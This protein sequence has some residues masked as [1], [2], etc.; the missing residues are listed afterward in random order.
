[1]I[2]GYRQPE[3]MVL[4]HA[5]DTAT[6][7]WE[8]LPPLPSPMPMANAV[9]VGDR[10]FVLGGME[11]PRS[12]EYDFDAKAWIP[13]APMPVER[14]RG[15]ASIGVHGTTVL[16]AGGVL[17][18][19]SINN[20]ATGERMRDLLPTTRLATC[21]RPGRSCRSPSATPHGRGGRRPVLRA[22][23]AATPPERTRSLVFDV[24]ARAWT[25]ST[26]LPLTLSSAAAGVIGGK[27]VVAGGIAST[28]GM[29]NPETFLFD[30][31]KPA[32]G[33]TTL[34]PIT[35][36]RFAMGGA[37]VDNRLYV[38]TGMTYRPGTNNIQVQAVTTFEAFVPGP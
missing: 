18:G 20:L 22:W 12:I 32:A 24:K 28:T 17:R 27:I 36:P 14:G 23:A 2:G 21:G 6:G 5:F 10:L 35:T 31:A 29:I 11:T 8:T 34:T 7:T 30:P 15:T 19:L 3:E 13:R 33:W 16:L 38:P 9:G 1:M 4:A 37:V 26:P 25:T